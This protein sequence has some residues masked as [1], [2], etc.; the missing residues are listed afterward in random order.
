MKINPQVDRYLIEGCGR[1]SLYQTPECKV[2]TWSDELSQL[3]A[4]VLDTGLKEDFKWS[5]PCYTLDN[6]NILL[7]TAF[8]AY[9]TIAFFKGSLLKDP[10][11]IL[12]APGKNS[13]AVRQLRFTSSKKIIEMSPII[14][15]YIRNAIEI[16]KTGV[17]VNFKKTPELIPDELQKK[18]D[19]NPSFKTAFQALTPGRQRGY[20]LHFSQPKQ[21]K[22]RADRIEKYSPQIMKGKGLNDMYKSTKK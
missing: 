20:I 14:K 12:T 8:K 1:C 5:Q 13:H 9:A 4:I 21:S 19:A 11:N 3:R 10:N 17:K 7:V 18:F 6:K 22:T 16:E 2:H 15:T